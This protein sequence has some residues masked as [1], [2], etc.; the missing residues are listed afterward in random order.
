MKLATFWSTHSSSP[1]STD[2]LIFFFA[3]RGMVDYG[4]ADSL[5]VVTIF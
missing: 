4:C 3:L 5:S 1:E 2:R